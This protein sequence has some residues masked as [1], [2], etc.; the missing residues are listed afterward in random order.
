MIYHIEQGEYKLFDNK[1]L[2]E[3]IIV[4]LKEK[5]N[6]GELLPG[7]QLPTEMELAEQ[8][9]VSR[10]TS[11]RALEELSRNNLIYRIRG[12]GSFVASRPEKFESVELEN[13]SQSSES[14]S[15][16]CQGQQKIVSIVLP[17]KVSLG[18]LMDVIRG[19][20]D[21]LNV[22]GYYLTVHSTS[23]DH[24]QQKAILRKL[25]S[26]G[27]AGIIY[28]PLS[29]GKNLEILNTLHLN[30]YPI[31]T[32]DKYIE[33]IPMSYVVSDNFSG[34]YQV[35]SHLISLGHRKIAF[36][37]DVTIESAT[38]ARNRYFGYCKAL[39]D[40]GLNID[41]DIIIIGYNEMEKYQNPEL[42]NILKNNYPVEEAFQQQ[43]FRNMIKD[44]VT[45]LLK[46]GVTAIQALNDTVA[47]YFEK[48][49]LD[50]GIK[51][52]EQVALAGFDNIGIS[53]HMD[54]PITTV[55]QNFY[56]MGMRAAEI[57]VNKIEQGK[58]EY[59]QVIIPVKMLERQSSG[60]NK[61]LNGKNPDISLIG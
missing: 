26:D 24:I 18:G 9:N 7:Q 34:G 61:V 43:V 51:I 46:H 14:N 39:K 37:S 6:S 59:A 44:I 10:I 45:V 53:E 16:Y 22:K 25:V 4:Y 12:S 58:K 2:Y 32:I 3:Q 33:S 31:V 41:H 30:N 57:V 52:P 27:I 42:L 19:A 5:I 21:F 29:D 28:Y 47:V 55:E 8:F 1:P 36:V 23:K 35:A 49:C 56:E 60:T 17:F 48:I 50:M 11:K 40:N 54:I 15:S 38:S 20:T 13:L